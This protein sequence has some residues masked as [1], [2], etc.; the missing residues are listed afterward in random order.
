M[1]PVQPPRHMQ[2]TFPPEEFL[3]PLP[4]ISLSVGIGMLSVS[5]ITRPQLL[6]PPGR[7]TV[8]RVGRDRAGA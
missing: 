8:A 2:T 5:S 3:L 7:H 1:L 6:V 4:E